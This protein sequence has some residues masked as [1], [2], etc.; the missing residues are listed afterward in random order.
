MVMIMMVKTYYI[1]TYLYLLLL[2]YVMCI[3]LSC[4]QINAE[5]K[6]FV[7]NNDLYRPYVA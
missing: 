6:Y 2:Y 4:L 3:F 5:G 7:R 1:F